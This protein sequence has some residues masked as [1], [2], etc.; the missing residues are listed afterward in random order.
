MFLHQTCYPMQWANPSVHPLR[1]TRF[2]DPLRT[3]WEWSNSLLN[4]AIYPLG[5]W[6]YH[7]AH[8]EIAHCTSQDRDHPLGQ[9]N[10]VIRRGYM[11]IKW[12]STMD[13]SIISNTLSNGLRTN[14]PW[15]WAL[16]VHDEPSW[17]SYICHTSSA[18]HWLEISP[19]QK[20]FWHHM[21]SRLARQR[22]QYVN[23]WSLL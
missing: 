10:H 1:M 16:S 3:V 18:S 14:I 19:S 22:N 21:A 12:N 23:T 7:P 11:Y 6:S 15:L 17:R 20:S 8:D 2:L 4:I 5:Q 13:F 9:T